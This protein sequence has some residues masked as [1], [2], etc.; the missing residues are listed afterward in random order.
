MMMMMILS[1]ISNV[2]L[3]MLFWSCSDTCDRD[4]CL[5]VCDRFHCLMAYLNDITKYHVLFVLC[6]YSG[7]HDGDKHCKSDHED[8]D[9]KET[10]A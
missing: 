6:F 1:I 5:I 7:H 2:K 9:E 3:F 10:L 8:V 4:L